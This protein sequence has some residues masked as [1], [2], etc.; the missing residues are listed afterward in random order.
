MRFT[1]ISAAA[2]LLTLTS[3]L[4]VKV[5]ESASLTQLSSNTALAGIN[6]PTEIKVSNRDDPTP[7]SSDEVTRAWRS[8]VTYITATEGFDKCGQTAI[9]KVHIYTRTPSNDLSAASATLRARQ[10]DDEPII[11]KRDYIKVEKAKTP[12]ST[13]T[14]VRVAALTPVSH[15]VKEKT[16]ADW[17]WKNVKCRDS[18]TLYNLY[19]PDFERSDNT[20]NYLAGLCQKWVDANIEQE[21]MLDS[22]SKNKSQA[23]NDV[24]AKREIALEES[25]LNPVVHSA[26][27]KRGSNRPDCSD[28]DV[29]YAM[30]GY[31]R[32]RSGFLHSEDMADMEARC[33]QFVDDHPTI[34]PPK[35]KRDISKQQWNDVDCTD[36]EVL[37]SMYGY[38]VPKSAFMRNRDLRD[39]EAKCKEFDENYQ[40]YRP[41][42]EDSKAK[43]EVDLKDINTEGIIDKREDVLAKRKYKIYPLKWDTLFSREDLKEGNTDCR[44][45][46]VLYDLFGPYFER[47]DV[48]MDRLAGLCQVGLRVKES[49]MRFTEQEVKAGEV[50]VNRVLGKIMSGEKVKRDLLF[51]YDVE[52]MASLDPE[53]T[54]CRDSVVLYDLFGPD[55]K[56]DDETMDNL[57]NLCRQGLAFMKHLEE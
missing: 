22:T 31:E 49:G 15:N 52:V 19:G 42:Q 12:T 33:E 13:S 3:A 8:Q 30:Y 34:Y 21:A 46:V 25:P 11:D 6:A 17:D 37:Y 50:D 44:N 41:E 48:T 29:L 38:D 51:P 5:A 14:V 45:S 36:P 47:D 1:A 54:D 53:T 57:A 28:F 55:F 35:A 56:R 16:G 9:S 7:T 27:S 40:R 10:W 4:P 24:V 32:S 26:M 23:P 18:V 2:T 20:M 43:R 39:L